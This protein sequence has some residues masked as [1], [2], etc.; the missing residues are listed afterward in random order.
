MGN[1][2]V[3][4]GNTEFPYRGKLH[5][6]IMPVSQDIRRLS[7]KEKKLALS[8]HA[9]LALTLSAALSSV[10]LDLKLLKKGERGEP[11]PS[12]GVYWSLSHTSD[13]VAAV[14]A[15]H[16]IGIDIE[17]VKPC[18]A[19]LQARISGGNE[20]ELADTIDDA[21]V[22]RF[23]TAKE[24][25]L[26]AIG[27]GLAGLDKCVVTEITDDRHMRLRFE[28]D[29]WVVSHCSHAFHHIAAITSA[30]EGVRWHIAAH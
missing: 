13:F 20:W 5:A 14:V 15:P 30:A 8:R 27:A 28:S 16:P 12:G 2:A 7:G 11:L 29:T 1:G 19:A 10:A 23:W 25:V 3:G 17:K 4:A 24:A 18:S 9:R 22:C 21:L 26:K 6:V